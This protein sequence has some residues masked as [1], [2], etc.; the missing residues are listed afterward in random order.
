M[1]MQDCKVREEKTPVEGFF[2][3]AEDLCYVL[4]SDMDRLRELHRHDGPILIWRSRANH[5][6]KQVGVLTRLI[7]EAEKVDG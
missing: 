1:Q 5:L 6:L 7:S 2:L 3:V 4:R